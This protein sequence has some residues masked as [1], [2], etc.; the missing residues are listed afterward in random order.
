M[1]KDQFSLS[2]EILPLSLR[3]FQSLINFMPNSTT[4]QEGFIMDDGIR[5]VPRSPTRFIKELPGSGFILK[6]VNKKGGEEI[7]NYDMYGNIL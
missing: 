5:D 3:E 6:T 2:K 1:S 4:T 7:T